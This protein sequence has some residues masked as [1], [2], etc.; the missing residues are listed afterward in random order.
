MEAFLDGVVDGE[1]L[2]ARMSVSRLGGGVVTMLA[3][4]AGVWRGVVI[5]VLLVD[6]HR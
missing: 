6:Q 1:V 4:L 5:A 2:P 3:G